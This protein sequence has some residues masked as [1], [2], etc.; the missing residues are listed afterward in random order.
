LNEIAKQI[1]WPRKPKPGFGPSVALGKIVHS[2]KIEAWKD[3]SETLN[4]GDGTT[5]IMAILKKL[6]RTF[7]A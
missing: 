4:V 7:R 5:G 3:T 1:K 6:E 2:G